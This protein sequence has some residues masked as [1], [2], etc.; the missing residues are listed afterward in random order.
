MKT[1][2]QYEG[3]IKSKDVVE[4]IASP[5]GVGPFCGFGSVTIDGNILKVHAQGADNSPFKNDILDRIN[6]RYL[7][8]NVND[9][10]YPDVW[11]GC[12]SRDGYIFISDDKE[13]GDI[14]IQGNQGVTRDVFLF[15]VHDEVTE[16]IE[17]PVSFVAYW[18]EG[19]ESLYTLYK[20]SINPYYPT[21]DT[22]HAWDFE[23]KDPYSNSQMNFTYLLKMVE[24]NCTKYRSTKDSMVL[25]GVYGSGT[26]SI[27]NTTENYAIIPYGGVFPQ[28]LPFT[29]AYKGLISKSVKRL[30]NMVGDIPSNYTSIKEYIEFLF[31]QYE[32]SV[33]NSYKIIPPGAIMLWSGTTPPEGWAL[34]DGV[35]GRPNL[36]DRFVKGWGPNSESIGT[37]GGTSG[38]ITINSNN[39][40]KHTHDYKDYFFLDHAPGG[41]GPIGAKDEQLGDYNVVEFNHRNDGHRKW[42]RYL[43][44]TTQSNNSANNPID[45]QPPYYVLAYIIKL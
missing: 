10:E 32:G 39:L 35:D 14:P 25:I 44:S 3:I 45:V 42:A 5:I 12:I 41:N 6:S 4:G 43:D 29:S 34:C 37:T 20:K 2:F 1:Y 18:S 36:I 15:A 17:N 21:A 9:G 7:K 22:N 26:D 38:K 8:K 13:L 31:E 24:S 28:P 19:Q 40:P 23:G 30:E 27:T 33:D 16:P 11:F